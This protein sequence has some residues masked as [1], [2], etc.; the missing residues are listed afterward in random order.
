MMTR[1]KHGSTPN[2]ARPALADPPCLTDTTASRTESANY[3]IPPRLPLAQRSG[4]A[5]RVALLEGRVFDEDG[6]L[7]Q[8]LSDE[9]VRTW[10]GEINDLRRDL[11]WLT[12]DLRHDYVW[13]GAIAS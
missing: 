3:G 5:T 9:A 8:G 2:P 4:L 6:H 11:G 10:L 1:A 13:P 12:L 7:R